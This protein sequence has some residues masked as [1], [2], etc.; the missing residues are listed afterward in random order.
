M[1]RAQVGNAKRA[2]L[3]L[4]EVPLPLQRVR[5]LLVVLPQGCDH[6]VDFQLLARVRP[7]AQHLPFQAKVSLVDQTTF[8][9]VNPRLVH[10]PPQR[11][12]HGE[13]G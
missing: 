12:V 13:K 1:A 8:V 6:L 5:E 10:K 7:V 4:G 11:Q 3:V 2:P 9:I